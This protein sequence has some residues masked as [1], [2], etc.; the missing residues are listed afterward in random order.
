MRF[1]GGTGRFAAIRETLT[2]DVEYYIRSTPACQSPAVT[3]LR[4]TLAAVVPVRAAPANRVH[5]VQELTAIGAPR[6]GLGCF[7]GST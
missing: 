5:T 6:T 4:I 2:Q 1:V 3:A 7:V